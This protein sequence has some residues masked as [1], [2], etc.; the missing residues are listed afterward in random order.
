MVTGDCFSRLLDEIA[1]AAYRSCDKCQGANLIMQFLDKAAV[2]AAMTWG[3]VLDAMKAGHRRPQP[4]LGDTL[5]LRDPDCMLVRT[6]WIDGLGIAVK[7]AAIF[8]GNASMNPPVPSIQ[9]YAMVY[10]DKTGGVE[11]II[12]AVSLTS[13]KTAGDS[14]LGSSML[15]RTDAKSL[16]MVGAG[17]MAEPLIRAHLSVR[18]AL[19]NVTIWNRSRPRAEELASKLT[20]LGRPVI[21]ADDLERTVRAA[22]IIS[23]ATMSLEPLIMGRWLKDGAHLDLVGAYRLD[24]H[25]ADGEAVKRARVWVDYRGTTIDHIGDIATPLKQGVITRDHI[26]GDLYDLVPGAVG[27]SNDRDITLFKN[28]G[29]A[30]LDLM[31]C[32]AILAAVVKA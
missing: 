9:G 5:L 24:M 11:A 32:R 30:H 14:A 18:P 29:G 15:S 3:H 31:T 20:D 17:A 22:D 27:R 23:V 13:W 6:A 4:R 10:D 7:A 25:E 16:A 2:N 1:V 12:D 19:D 26:L 8:P 21:I 28:G